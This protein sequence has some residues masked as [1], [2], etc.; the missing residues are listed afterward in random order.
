MMGLRAGAGRSGVTA[1][2]DAEVARAAELL[3]EAYGLDVT[4]RFNSDRRSGGAWLVTDFEGLG[5]RN[6]A[7]GLTVALVDVA[8]LRKL[9]DKYPDPDDTLEARLAGDGQDPANP[10][11]AYLSR[12]VML[13]PPYLVD[14]ALATQGVEADPYACVHVGSLEEGMALIAD[15]VVMPSV[16]PMP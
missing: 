6:N 11:A 14:T 5:G 10:P 4:I 16:G 1:E 3:R 15:K 9:Y 8:E 12:S 2:L 7:V 13:R